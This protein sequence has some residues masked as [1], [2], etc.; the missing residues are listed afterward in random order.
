MFSVAQKRHIAVEVEKQSAP[1][2]EHEFFMAC[3]RIGMSFEKARELWKQRR[4]SA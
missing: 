4:T 3:A 2:T 1:L